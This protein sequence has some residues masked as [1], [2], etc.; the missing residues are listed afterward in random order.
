MAREPF[1]IDRGCGVEVQ[2]AG[3]STHRSGRDEL[4]L[5]RGGDAPACQLG[6]IDAFKRSHH[7]VERVVRLGVR[8]SRRAE[9]CAKGWAL[10]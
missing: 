7:A 6:E 1:P 10:P 8:A 9:P 2:L 4:R 5:S 3:N